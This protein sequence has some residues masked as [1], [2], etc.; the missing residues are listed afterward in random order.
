M[1]LYWLFLFLPIAYFI[2][3]ANPAILIAKYVKKTDITK[4]GSGNPGMTNMLRH[5][6]LKWGIVV[7]SADVLKGV[8][9]ALFGLLFFGIDTYEGQIAMYSLGLSSVLGHCFP[10]LYKF[11]GGKGIS[12][13]VGVFL[14]A[15]PLL[16]FLVL[17][18]LVLYWMIFEYGALASFMFLTVLVIYQGMQITPESEGAIAI[19]SL[20]MA[21]YFFAWYTHRTNIVRLLCG[22][23][24][25]SSLFKKARR[26]RLVIRQQEWK[27]E[28]LAEEMDA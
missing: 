16:S 25:Y 8:I 27:Q 14:V 23:E 21:F 24:N 2:G 28:V 17:F 6:G 22:K 18:V 15:N 13:M 7:F 12:S 4:M 3:N 11:K 20:L 19:L 5:F 26:K 9:P 10:V 1:E